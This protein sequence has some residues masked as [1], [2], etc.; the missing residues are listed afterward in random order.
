MEA[1]LLKELRKKQWIYQNII[2]LV[3]TILFLVL[4]FSGVSSLIV[5]LV[6]GGFLILSA[7]IRY[8]TKRPYLFLTIFPG[9]RE[10]EKYE[11]DKLGNAWLKFFAPSMILPITVGLVLFI[12][13]LFRGKQTPF[14]SGIPIWYFIIAW[15]LL[16]YIGNM[17]LRFH[18][19]RMDQ[20]S[21]ETIREYAQE[22][23]TFAILFTIVVLIMSSIGAIYVALVS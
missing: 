18:I 20:S 15:I 9:M 2:F 13:A 21:A 12:Q 8:F 1:S 4:V 3:Y 10:I 14:I 23:M 19:R 7:V 16:I 5:F 11:R 17:N 22:K 6:L